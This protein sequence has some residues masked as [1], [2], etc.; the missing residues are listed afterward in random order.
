MADGPELRRAEERQKT[1]LSLLGD[2]VQLGALS[3]SR[4]NELEQLGALFFGKKDEAA[5]KPLTPTADVYLVLNCS[6][7]ELVE[8]EK[9][10]QTSVPPGAT[11]V[12]YNLEVRL[13]LFA[14]FWMLRVVGELTPNDPRACLC[15][16]LETARGDL[17]LPGFPSK[18][19]HYRFLSRFKSALFLRQRSYSKTVNVAPFLLNY[20]GATFREYPGPWQVMLRAD[21]GELACIAERAERYG[22]GEAKEEMMAAMGLNTEAEG[23]SME[24]LR[25]GYKTATW[26][27]EGTAEE[28][29]SAWRL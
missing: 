1:T 9:W 21:S 17:G 12:A 23:S 6:T 4:L 10:M 5:A 3:G 8:V 2:S 26:W 7:T 24:F 18:E 22:L 16:Q 29:S 25:R 19:L 15:V 14:L 11:V 27:E 20:D 13:Y 28:K